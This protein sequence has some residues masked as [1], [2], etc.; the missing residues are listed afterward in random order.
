MDS[1]FRPYPCQGAHHC[2]WRGLRWTGGACRS[3][4]RA[5]AL[6]VRIIF[7]D[8][9]KLPERTSIHAAHPPFGHMVDAAPDT[10]RNL[11]CMAR[12]IIDMPR[13]VGSMAQ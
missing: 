3:R 9:V 8:A 6:G 11:R 10:P 2:V 5:F 7:E 13:T 1:F 4:I 12:K